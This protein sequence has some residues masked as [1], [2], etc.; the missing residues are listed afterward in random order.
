MNT[1]L[2]FSSNDQTWATPIDFFL[3][4]D[5]EFDFTLDP[6]CTKETAKCST[7][8]TPETDGLHQSW[9]GHSVFM[10]PPYGDEIK[11]WIEKAYVESNNNNAQVV[12]LIPSRTDTKYWH[13]YCMKADE[14]RFIKGRLKFGNSNSAAPFP[15][16]VVIFNN[17]N[18]VPK[19]AY[20]NNKPEL[21]G[22]PIDRSLT[23]IIRKK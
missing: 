23:P 11:Y 12:C 5:N 13:D 14:I 22:Q 17:S 8:F 20:M 21:I 15:S 4:L 1:E 6:C 19:I 7:Y 16:A 10:N 3:R 18:N 9:D 2:F